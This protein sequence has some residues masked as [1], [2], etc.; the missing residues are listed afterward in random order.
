MAQK[1]VLCC[2]GT[3]NGK[4]TGTPDT[5]V[6]IFANIIAD[7]TLNN[8]IDDGIRTFST[9]G[10]AR[11]VYFDGVGVE[12]TITDYLV[13]A[14][15][16]EDIRT[17]CIEAYKFIVEEF[18]PGM[19][20]W[21]LGFSRGAY[22]TRC[23]AGM[24]NNIGIIDNTHISDDRLNDL[25]TTAYYMY[26]SKDPEYEPKGACSIEFKKTYSHNIKYPPVEFMGLFDTVGSL[27]V[28]KIDPGVSLS[29][30]FYDQNISTEV[31]HVFQA[32]ATHDRLFAFEPCFARRK[33]LIRSAGGTVEQPVEFWFQGAHYDIGRVRF[34]PLRQGRSVEGTLRFIQ[35][36]TNIA[37][38]NV[39][40]TEDY[41]SKV[42]RWMAGC[43]NNIDENILH[44]REG[45]YEEYTHVNDPWLSPLR[46]N[47]YDKLYD[48]VKWIPF[49]DSVFGRQVLR[50]RHVPIS[51][52]SIF[53][54][55]NNN[56]DNASFRSSVLGHKSR[57]FD[58]REATTL[59]P[60]IWRM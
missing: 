9:D 15:I 37:R 40:F 28:P 12:G 53:Y 31:E 2:D 26:R 1:I 16:A 49:V 29:Y 32:L 36:R 7:R 38:L 13:D 22:T 44:G 27:G 56:P 54:S 48:R 23:I 8:S 20:I 57:A 21:T 34:A 5:N 42:F 3:W 60:I 43:M 24:I 6:K 45:L 47:A 30:D 58:V 18:S 51:R 41:S 35:S 4:A 10:Y 19:K 25:C 14:A 11:V 17:K 55:P 46:L 52:E 33:E 39:Y 50:D 59:N